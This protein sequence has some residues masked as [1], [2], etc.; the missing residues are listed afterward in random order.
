M[1]EIKLRTYTWPKPLFGVPT[2]IYTIAG[3]YHTGDLGWQGCESGT[4]LL[5]GGDA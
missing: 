5:G 2:A 4:A 1:G 3:W